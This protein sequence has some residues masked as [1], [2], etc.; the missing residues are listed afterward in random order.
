MKTCSE[1]EP[2]IQMAVV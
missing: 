1:G 2:T